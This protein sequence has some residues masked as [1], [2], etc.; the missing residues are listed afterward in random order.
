VLNKK[1]HFLIIARVRVGGGG[2][3]W[4]RLHLSYVYFVIPSHFITVCANRATRTHSADYAVAR[5]LSVCLSLRPS[6]TRRYSV[7]TAE[8]ILNFLPSGSPTILVFSHQTLWQY[9]DGD[10][11]T[12][13]SNARGVKIAIFD[14]YLA[15]FPR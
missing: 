10:P 12:A 13:A 7:D 2:S 15:L 1:L 14:Q 5:C 4:K 9:S 8:H 3:R 11:L 6:V